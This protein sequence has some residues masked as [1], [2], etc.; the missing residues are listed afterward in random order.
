MLKVAINYGINETLMNR[1]NYIDFLSLIIEMQIDTVTERIKMKQ[2][3]NQANKGYEVRKAT[4]E[5]LI[6]MHRR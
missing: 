3:K 1:L 6:N 2:Q 4:N 5:E